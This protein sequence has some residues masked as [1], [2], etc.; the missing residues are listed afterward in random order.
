MIRRLRNRR[1]RKLAPNA[2]IVYSYL[3]DPSTR[4]IARALQMPKSTVYDAWQELRKAGLA[5]GKWDV[6]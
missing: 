1:I 6:R 2:A 3:T 4:E 5:K